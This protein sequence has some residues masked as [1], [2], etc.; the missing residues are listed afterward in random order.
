MGVIAKSTHD[1]YV[2]IGNA[3]NKGEYVRLWS[4]EDDLVGHAKSH[5]FEKSDRD[6]VMNFAHTFGKN[7]EVGIYRAGARSYVF[8]AH[9]DFFDQAAAII[10]RDSQFQQIRSYPMLIDYA[11]SLCSRVLPAHDFK[12][13]V[14]FK[15]AKLGQFEIAISEKDLR[16]R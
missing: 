12:R 5:H 13:M 16:R 2:A 6:K 3:L 9:K 10:M 7:I 4:I 11:D 1:D 8:Q 15:L 14:E